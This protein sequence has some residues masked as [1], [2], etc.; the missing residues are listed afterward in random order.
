MPLKPIGIQKRTVMAVLGTA[1]LALVIFGSG[2]AVYR[3]VLIKSR[4]ESYLQPYAE[5]I[6]VGTAVAVDLED[7]SRAQAILNS[8]KSNPQ[9]VRAE[10]LLSDGRTL[11]TYP[12]NSPPL[13]PTASAR[14]DGIFF[15]AGNAELVQTFSTDDGKP[16][17]LILHMNL[18][19]MRQR[20][21]QML[22]DLSAG[23]GLILLVIGLLQFVLLRRWVLSPLAQL[24]AIAENASQQGDY[25]RRMPAHDRDEFGQLGKSFNALLAAVEQRETALRQL[26]NFQRAIV[27]DAAYAILSTDTTGRITSFN[28]AGEKL[29]GWRAEELVGKVTP[30]V[31]YLPEE[32]AARAQQLSAKLGEPV[33][34]GF[35][36]FAA[37][38]RRGLHSEAEATLRHKDGSRLPVLLS[39]T[40]LRDER[41]EIFGF[42]GMVVDIAAR[43]QAEAQLRETLE[44]NQQLA[45]PRKW[46]STCSRRT[47]L[48]R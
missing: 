44:F 10:I 1:L 40:A 43:R 37:E 2:L 33:P 38:A 39:V 46:A 26:T 24:A 17:H 14:P 48:W 22:E 29:L 5:M 42:L 41:G 19:V 18:A 4:V 47:A 15:A 21:R 3:E 11:A 20:D 23:V 7:A 30:E 31:F 28:P 27:S 16:A 6:S 35:E 8:L 9:I 25:S 32:M 36:T 13:E 12:A 34:A 45:R